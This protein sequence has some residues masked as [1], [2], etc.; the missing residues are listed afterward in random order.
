[1]VE[2]W[3]LADMIRD[4]D[5]YLLY[6]AKDVGKTSAALTLGWALH[7][8]ENYSMTFNTTMEHSSA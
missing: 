8:F 3:V 5:C 7:K 4:G 2:N 1:M 6:A